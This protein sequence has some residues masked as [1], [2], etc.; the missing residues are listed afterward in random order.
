MYFIHKN[1]Y[2]HRDLKP[3]NLLISE[4]NI[5]KI[6]DFGWT[7]EGEYEQFHNSFDSEGPT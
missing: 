1:G 5:L 4:D 6:C 3:E 2:I 7:C